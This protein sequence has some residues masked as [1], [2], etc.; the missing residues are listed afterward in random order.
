MARSRLLPDNFTLTLIA[1]VALASLLPCSGQTAQVFGWVTNL[2][3]ALLFFLHGAKLSR[4]AVIAGALHWRLHLLIFAC[5][6]VLFPLLGLALKPLLAPAVGHELYMG[7]LYLCALPATVQSAIAFTSLARGNIP[8][9]ICSA[10]AS[11]LFGIFLTPLLVALLLDVHGDGGSMLDA[12]GKITLQLLVPFIAGQIARRWI[13]AWVGRNKEWLKYVDQGSILLVVYTAFSEA[14]IE[15]LWH[16]VSLPTLAALVGACCLLLALALV[17][18]HLLGK[19]LGF[20]LE[21]RITILFC[22]SKKSLATGVPMAQVLFA[23]GSIGLIILPLMLFHQI[24]LMVCA[25]LAQ[26]YARRPAEDEGLARAE[27]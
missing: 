6:F 1:V 10:A 23:G 5:T 4:E 7:I 25:V 27:S 14:V 12:M 3:I 13:G 19:W 2:A 15:G 9:A 20:S 22:G 26:R 24:Q 18:T 8:A 16:Q 11:S 21:D 17:L